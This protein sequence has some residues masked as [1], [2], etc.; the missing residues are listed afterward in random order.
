MRDRERDRDRDS[1]RERE[2]AGWRLASTSL[3]YSHDV[4]LNQILFK[5]F[6]ASPV[7]STITENII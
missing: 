2:R 4:P 7:G 3:T 6:F 5:C 1:E